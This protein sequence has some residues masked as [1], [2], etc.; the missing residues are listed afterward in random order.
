MPRYLNFIRG[1][2]DSDDLPLNVSRETLQQSKVLKVISKKLVRKALEMIRKLAERSKEKAEEETEEDA[3]DATEV[4]DEYL[5][6]WNE[7]GK[8]IKLGLIEDSSNRSK[9]SKLLRFRSSTQGEDLTSLE[10]YIERMKPWQKAI[11]YIA[12]ENVEAVENSPFME[13]FHAKEIEVLYMT[14]PIDEY[15]LQNLAEFD[16]VKLQS[17][18]KEGI[19]FGDE[20][21]V[22][23]RRLEAY[24]DQYKPLTT[25]LKDL[26]K[27]KVEKVVVSDRV[28][29]TPALL[30]TSQ[31]GYSANME[32]ILKAQAFADPKRAQYLMS[33]K[34]LELNP[35]HPIVARLLERVEADEGKFSSVI[36][37]FGFSVF[38]TAYIFCRG[39]G[40]KGPCLDS[41]RYRPSEQRFHHGED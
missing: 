38:L 6:F 27:G 25:Y 4:K 24:K 19:K 8:N 12:G 40:N 1:V 17:I 11:Y 7:F 14:D 9:L 2:V 10:D 5:E 31:Y 20:E 21:D 28:A 13:K 33:Q 26:L 16:G 22:D 23:Q 29:N 37:D 36:C 18:T 30:A 41:V 34:T 15:C 39:R 35:R 3:E 32:R